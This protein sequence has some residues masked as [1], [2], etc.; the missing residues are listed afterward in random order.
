MGPAGAGADV[1]QGGVDFG[2]NDDD[3]VLLLLLLE[4]PFIMP[5]EMEKSAGLLLLLLLLLLKS[6]EV[7]V[8]VVGELVIEVAAT[9][10]GAGGLLG[11]AIGRPLS[12]LV[13]VAPLLLP[14]LASK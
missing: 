6:E 9:G 2:P 7:L 13:V 14:F 1:F 3:F 8:D 11:F 5:G 12:V 4:A 10:A